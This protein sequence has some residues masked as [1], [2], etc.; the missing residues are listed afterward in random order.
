MLRYCRKVI[1]L[2]SKPVWKVIRFIENKK[3][4]TWM[5]DNSDGSAHLPMVFMSKIHQF[6]MH[7]ASFSQNSI[8]TNKIKTGDSIFKTKQVSVLVKLASFFFAKMQEHIDD[9]SIPKDVSAFAKSFFVKA[10]GGGSLPHHRPPKPPS[11]PPT[12]Q[13]KQ[14][15]MESVKATAMLSSKQT[16]ARRKRGTP[17]TRA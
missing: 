11:Q 9:N 14:T 15:A 7:L 8:N 5:C 2:G 12:S 17:P 4:N 3:T 16:Q 13:P 6:F 10:T 1:Q